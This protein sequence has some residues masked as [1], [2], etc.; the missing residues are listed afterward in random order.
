MFENA[1]KRST[2]GFSWT[3]FELFFCWSW[4][5]LVICKSLASTSQGLIFWA[6][7]GHEY[8]LLVSWTLLVCPSWLSEW[9][10]WWSGSPTRWLV[11]CLDLIAADRHI[12]YSLKS[13][14]AVWVR[15]LVICSTTEHLPVTESSRGFHECL[16]ITHWDINSTVPGL[17]SMNAGHISTRDAITETI[18][19]SCEP[20][21]SN[22]PEN[23]AY[24]DE[25]VTYFRY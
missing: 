19:G 15:W 8:F 12:F 18:F 2:G 7:N 23:E 9:D 3:K 25:H 14:L 20:V 22:C 1:W 17:I 16:G 5:E 21:N 11:I 13:H 10:G 6:F 24:I 4:V